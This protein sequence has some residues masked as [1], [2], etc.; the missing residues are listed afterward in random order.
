MEFYGISKLK[1]IYHTSKHQPSSPYIN[2]IIILSIGEVKFRC[3]IVK[4]SN[5]SIILFGRKIIVTQSQI[6]NFK[7]FVLMID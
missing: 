4:R 3:F 2:S 5:F 7:L 1:Q 6:N